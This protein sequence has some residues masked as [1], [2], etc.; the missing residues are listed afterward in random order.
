[1]RVNDI[2]DGAKIDRKTIRYV[3][4]LRKSTVDEGRQT[5]S[6]NDQ[7]TACFELMERLGIELIN[8]EEDV[9]EEQESAR[10]AHNRPKFDNMM[11]K[12]RT[13]FYAG[14]IAYHPDRL[15]RNMLEAGEILYMLTPDKGETESKIKDLIFPTTSFRNDSGNRMMLAV[16]FSMA[17]QYS[18]HL[19][20]V[21]KRGVDS[22]LRAGKSSGAH[23]WGYKRSAQGYYVPDH[24]FEKIRKGWELILA[25]K[26]QAEIIDYWR[27]QNVYYDTK[28][29]EKSPSKRIY[30]KHKNAVSRLFH[31]PFYYGIL[32]QAGQEV[33]LRAI[34]DDFQP[35]VNEE[36][37]RKVQLLLDSKYKKR[38]RKSPTQIFLPFRGMVICK[39]CGHKM[40]VS[41]NRN[42]KNNNIRIVYYA[43]Q[44]K[45]CPRKSK[46]LR[47]KEL[48][49][50]LYSYLDRI[51]LSKEA[52]EEYTYAIDNYANVELEELRE[53]RLSLLGSKSEAT[54]KR[55]DAND[56]LVALISAKDKGQNI[57]QSTI[58]KAADEIE[59]WHNRVLQYEDDIK[60][61]E[62]KLKDP[63]Q[64]K[65]TKEDFLNLV[66]N[67]GKQ[68]RKANSVE[69][70][71]IARKLFLNLVVDKKNNLTVICKPEFDGLI[72][73]DK[74]PSGGVM[75]T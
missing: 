4:Y 28:E 58:D 61:I 7:K 54:K 45:R 33:D 63:A 18:E 38:K 27:E 34:Q 43:C 6:I 13:G 9:I 69:K 51:H 74:V 10:Y 67:V 59:K 15:A 44:N 24:N 52:Y 41:A 47:G 2:Y 16:E 42:R 35:M 53:R 21:V 8:P 49:S 23:K 62:G 14:V 55:D 50:Q 71:I 60:K 22:H 29:T 65:L 75:W 32:C 46:Y 37:Y 57:P 12:I 68:M 26:S 36:D 72:S 17:T 11:N 40:Y 1:M 70:D 20:E 5:F 30:L 25:G 31:D 3:V 48:L 19:Q 64:I 73:F 56:K 39:E 66:Q